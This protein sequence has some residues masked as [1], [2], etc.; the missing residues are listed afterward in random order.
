MT[1][2][3]L[4]VSLIK[5]REIIPAE[6]DLAIVEITVNPHHS[7]P[8]VD[9]MRIK[10]SN[11]YTLSI[12]TTKISNLIYGSENSYEISIINKDGLLVDVFNTGDVVYPYQTATEAK[13]LILQVSRLSPC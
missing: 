3:K 10:F 9:V 12:L 8:A 13:D 1:N 4:C 7:F 5:N 6:L 11:E 2:E